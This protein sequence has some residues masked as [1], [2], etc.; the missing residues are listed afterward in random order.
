MRRLSWLYVRSLLLAWCGV[1]GLV[2]GQQGPVVLRVVEDNF[3]PQPKI[4]SKTGVGLVGV[5]AVRE[6]RKGVGLNV[7]LLLPVTYALPNAT[8]MC[9][10]AR[11]QDA[12]FSFQGEASAEQL[13]SNH[14]GRLRLVAQLKEDSLTFLSALPL[15]QFALWGRLGSC[16]GSVKESQAPVVVA[17]DPWPDSQVAIRALRV[18]LNAP[19][20]RV[21]LR[22]G[23]KGQPKKE[24]PCVRSESKEA[25]AYATE[26]TILLPLAKV[27]EVEILRY[28]FNATPLTDRFVL[29]GPQSLQV[30]R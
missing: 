24:Q 3:E 27:T 26:C 25:G 20:G 22:F 6:D 29:L 28:R 15:S 13:R 11:S 18:L 21:G 12:R 23:A 7:D 30:Q 5:V 10:F 14:D 8:P 19:E 9:I 1:V 2:Y 17:L 4:G 16:V